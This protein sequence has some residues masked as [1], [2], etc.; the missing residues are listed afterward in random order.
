MKNHLKSFWQ[1]LKEFLKEGLSI[2]H[3][4]EALNDFMPCCGK[5]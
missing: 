5:K 1:K 2:K 3:L 4:K